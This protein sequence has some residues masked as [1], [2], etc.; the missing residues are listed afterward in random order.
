M[1][2]DHCVHF[3]DISC[4]RAR[5]A[6]V[7]GALV[8]LRPKALLMQHEHPSLL[9]TYI[10]ASDFVVMHYSCGG[11]VLHVGMHIGRR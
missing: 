10:V 1:F 5:V 6:R 4:D 9:A 3:R 11:F 2:V 7:F 8:Q